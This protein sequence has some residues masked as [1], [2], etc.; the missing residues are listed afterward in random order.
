MML[1]NQSGAPTD[2]TV[3]VNY[4]DIGYTTG[5]PGMATKVNRIWYV[6]AGNNF[7]SSTAKANMKLFYTKRDWTNWA[8]G[9]K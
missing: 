9:E 1:N 6:A 8:T 2:F 5:T 4:G 7:D 3:V